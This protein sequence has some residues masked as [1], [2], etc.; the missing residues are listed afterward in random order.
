MIQI[1]IIGLMKIIMKLGMM[2]KEPRKINFMILVIAFIDGTIMVSQI[3]IQIQY[4]IVTNI[5]VFLPI[6]ELPNMLV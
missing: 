1:M 4:I 3:L 5:P 2:E 6:K